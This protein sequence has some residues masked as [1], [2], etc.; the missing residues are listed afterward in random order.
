MAPYGERSM[1]FKTLLTHISL[2]AIPSSLFIFGS[3]TIFEI[4]QIYKKHRDK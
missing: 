4:L 1:P 2:L 3:K